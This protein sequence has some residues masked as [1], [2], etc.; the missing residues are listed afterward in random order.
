MIIEDKKII[1]LIDN[2]PNQPPKFW[3]KNWIEINDDSRETVNTNSKIKLKTSM[4][5]S[6]L[7]CFREAYILVNRT[8]RIIEYGGKDTQQQLDERNKAEIFNNCAPFTGFIS[9]IQ[10][11][12]VENAKDL[13]VVMPT[14]NLIKYSNS[15]S[16]TSERL[17]QY[18]NDETNDILRN[19]ETLKYKI[20]IIGKT[21]AV[22]NTIHVKYQYH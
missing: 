22:A 4:L 5:E 9:A 7:C 19:C 8:L 13:D 17:C 16:K 15:Y 2:T 10:N 20:K 1:K 14:Y 12:Q 21:R 6:N 3:T 11:I 18:Y